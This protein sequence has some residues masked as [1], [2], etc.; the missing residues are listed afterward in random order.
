[1]HYYG[2]IATLDEPLL[3]YRQIA[4]V[5]DTGSDAVIQCTAITI[6]VIIVVVMNVMHNTIDTITVVLVA[7][8]VAAAAAC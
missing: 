8:S 4:C 7:P 5:S 2:P 6:I 3:Y 1:M